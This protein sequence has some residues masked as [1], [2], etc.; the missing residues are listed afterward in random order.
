MGQ[1]QSN[2][3]HNLSKKDYN[4]YK[5]RFQSLNSELE[6]EQKKAEGLL[7]D[8]EKEKKTSRLLRS[9]LDQLSSVIPRMKSD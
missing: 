4:T 6:T 3:S 5:E 2:G 7:Q 1:T 9:K 8:L